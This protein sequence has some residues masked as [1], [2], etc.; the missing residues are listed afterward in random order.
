[1]FDGRAADLQRSVIAFEVNHGLSLEQ[2]D[3]DT[4][5]GAVDD[6]HS[7]ITQLLALSINE[8]HRDPVF[9][10]NNVIERE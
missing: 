1:M 8:P 9:T 2:V 10:L 3:A 7:L 4:G 6:D 5:F